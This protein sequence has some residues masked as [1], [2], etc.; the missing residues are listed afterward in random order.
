MSHHRAGVA[1]VLRQHIPIGSLDRLPRASTV[2]TPGASDSHYGALAPA[3][4]AALDPL[5][6]ATSAHC[7]QRAWQ[8][9]IEGSLGSPGILL[10]R[11]S[12]RSFFPR[13]GSFFDGHPVPQD[14]LEAI[15][16]VA[17][18]LAGVERIEHRKRTGAAPRAGKRGGHKPI[19]AI[20]AAMILGQKI[21]I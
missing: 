15:E 19:F 12:G 8:G 16:G 18:G 6:G 2:D 1:L 14:Y 13:R 11:A 4:N 3:E 10:T 9:A 5:N 17:A 21:M 20:H 7:G